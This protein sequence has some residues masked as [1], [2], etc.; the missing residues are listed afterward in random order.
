MIEEYREKVEKIGTECSIL[1]AIK[2]L[3]VPRERETAQLKLMDYDIDS[4]NTEELEPYKAYD[5]NQV[6]SDKNTLEN[7]LSALE[8]KL[9]N[10]KKYLPDIKELEVHAII[11]AYQR[12]LPDLE[13]N[14]DYIKDMLEKYNV[15]ENVFLPQEFE[16]KYKSFLT[17][18]GQY[19]EVKNN[20]KNT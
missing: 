4:D 8:N 7:K 14:S 20:K 3:D 5:L 9:N 17:K 6:K 18:G 2:Q 12:Y 19:G 1:E 10:H 13:L 11:Y 16:E 15:F